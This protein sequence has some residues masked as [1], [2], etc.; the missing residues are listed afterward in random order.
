MLLWPLC[1]YG[2]LSFLTPG[3]AQDCL[4]DAAQPTAAFVVNPP[5]TGL[6]MTSHGPLK[7]LI[8]MAEFSDASGNPLWDNPWI[9]S[10]GMSLDPT[11]SF[12]NDPI[13]G[14]G[15]FGEL[16]IRPTDSYSVDS[17]GVVFN[18]IRNYNRNG[19]NAEVVDTLVVELSINATPSSIDLFFNGGAT[20]QVIVNLAP[21]SPGVDTVRWFGMQM[22][23]A[24]NGFD[25]TILPKKAYKLPMDS[26]YNADSIPG[27]DGRHY[28]EFEVT[29][30]GLPASGPGKYVFLTYYFKP[31]FSYSLA[32]SLTKKNYMQFLSFEENGANTFPKYQERDWNASHIFRSYEKYSLAPA[33]ILNDHQAASFAFMGGTSAQGAA[34]HFENHYVNFKLSCASCDAISTNDIDP[35]VSKLGNAYPNPA[36][37]GESL[38]I[39]VSLAKAGDATIKI[40]N[41]LGQEVKVINS[42]DLISGVNNIN[43]NTANLNAGVYLY[44]LELNGK[45]TATQRFTLVK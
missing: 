14:G 18:Y 27:I 28:W 11:S 19:S 3:N 16:L 8:I 40:Y 12:F 39:P 34:Y 25:A 33:S 7:V 30:T 15:G 45:I 35:N 20:N 32:D 44:S 42:K 24:T 29:G 13:N 21:T 22:N 26:A 36:E 17:V 43:V 2:Q 38:T 41:T 1:G 6:Y 10:I 5:N 4:P 23:S 37:V 31:G 9:H